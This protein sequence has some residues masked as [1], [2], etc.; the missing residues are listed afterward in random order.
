VLD[1]LGVEPDAAFNALE[2]GLRDA[3]TVGRPIAPA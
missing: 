2:P 3:L 1:A